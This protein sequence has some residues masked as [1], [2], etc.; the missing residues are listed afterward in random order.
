MEFYTYK[1]DW[2]RLESGESTQV[3]VLKI[4][5]MS[6]RP[7]VK[8]AVVLEE[9]LPVRKEEE[10]RNVVEFKGAEV[11]VQEPGLRCIGNIGRTL[12]RCKR[13]VTHKIVQKNTRKFSYL[14]DKCAMKYFT[15]AVSEYYD[16]VKL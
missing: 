11:P 12:N 13:P 7:V 14:C 5:Y 2:M 8:L 15:T 10:K 3:R 16:L 4:P 6:T 9:E 1:D